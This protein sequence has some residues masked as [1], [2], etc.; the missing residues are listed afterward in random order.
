MHAAVLDA[1]GVRRSGPTTRIPAGAPGTALVAVTAAP[2]VPLDLLCASGVSYFGGPDVPYVPGVQG[3]GV[4]ERSG[5]SPPGTR[6]FVQHDGRHGAGRRQPGRAVRRCRRRP[7]AAG[8][9]RHRRRA[10]RRSGMSGGRRLD[11]PHRARAGCSPAS[12]CW[13][14]ARAARWGRSAV[15]AAKLLGA[16]RVVA[17]CRSEEALD[18]AWRPARTRS[19]RSRATST[20]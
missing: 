10:S 19:S 4:V 6:V 14:W 1:P 5:P 11:D 8:G 17:V 9:R 3:V 20:R 13:S 18:R 7:R 15:G 2:I 16:G 12:R